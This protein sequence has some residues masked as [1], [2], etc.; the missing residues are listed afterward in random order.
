M[1]I[2]Q[3]KKNAKS[4]LVY[5]VFFICLILIVL[6]LLIYSSFLYVIEYEH[7][8]N[9]LST[10]L[11]IIADEKVK[12]FEESV[13]FKKSILNSL[14]ED[15]FL[16]NK[17]DYNSFFEKKE[18][19]F[20]LKSIFLL[21]EKNGSL[22]ATFSSNKGFVNKNFSFLK[23]I[24][25]KDF[26]LFSN[27][28]INCKGCLFLS[29][30]IKGKKA[31]VVAF[32]QNQ[33]FSSISR[34][35]FPYPVNVS[36]VNLSNIVVSTKAQKSSIYKDSNKNILQ[37]KRKLKPFDF[38]LIL[39]VK[40]AHLVAIHIKQFFL[41][42]LLFLL[43]VFLIALILSLFLVRK[44]SKP[45]N[46]LLFTM[47][48]VKEGDMYQRYK[49][50]RWGFEFN[51]IGLFFN[52]SI[53]SLIKKQ[54]QLEKARFDKQKYIDELEIA[55]D[56]QLKMLPQKMVDIK[57]IDIASGYLPAKEVSGDFFDIL[58]K[59]GKIFITIADIC[60]KGIPACLYSLN[61]RSI[62][63]AY[64]SY[65]KKLDDIIIETNKLFLKDVQKE[66]IF[67]TAFVG[68]LDVKSKRLIYSSFGHPP[69]LLRKKNGKILELQTKNKALGLEEVTQ[70]ETK[71]I[72]LEKEDFLFLYTDGIVDAIDENHK[73]FGLNN[74]KTFLKK[75]PITSSKQVVDDLFQEVNNYSKNVFQYDDMTALSFK[76]L[77]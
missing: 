11:N 21:E 33:L 31:I 50:Q 49:K 73:I 28:A 12:L 57:G 13:S 9:T 27:E 29:K 61:L 45:V 3:N 46:H 19:D 68:I 10:S 52:D 58:K 67:A 14:D 69:T 39:E 32:S 23:N 16:I 1:S 4:Y 8:V 7:K 24:L 77:K 55:K 43:L 48:K 63:R 70:I 2:A 47:H 34:D 59:D 56:I 38:D 76:I 26:S 40:K 42:H 35:E 53:S 20:N 30:T 62:I 64:G 71:E 25:K 36:I 44:L 51:K 17:D 75:S 41:R 37:I 65:F 72:R 15:L 60:G 6:P 22:I 18:K 74:L 5:R 54:K 66:C